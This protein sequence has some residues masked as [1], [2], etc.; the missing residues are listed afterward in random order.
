MAGNI[1]GASADSTLSSPIAGGGLLFAISFYILS[2]VADGGLLSTV[3]DHFLSPITGGGLSSLIP[4]A[5]S[6]ALFLTSTLSH[7]H[8]FSFLF[9]S[10]FYSFLPPSLTPLTYNPI[11][12]IG[13]RLFNQVFITQRSIA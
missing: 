11:P 9:L 1:D 2:P 3:F 12:F 5:G 13:K 4:P 7:T 6:Q 8:Y 10:F